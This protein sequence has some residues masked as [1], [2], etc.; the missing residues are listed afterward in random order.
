MAYSSY[1]FAVDAWK[2]NSTLARIA[3]TIAAAGPARVSAVL[4]ENNVTED[5]FKARA[6]EAAAKGIR[7]LPAYFYLGA[8][9][10]ID[11]LAKADVLVCLN[12]KECAARVEQ[13]MRLPLLRGAKLWV[14][15]DEIARDAP[16]SASMPIVGAERIL[17]FGPEVYSYV[18][19]SLDYAVDIPVYKLR[20][21]PD[22]FFDCL[23]SGER[24][25][26]RVLF[27]LL[28]SDLDESAS[29][30]YARDGRAIRG[31]A[32]AA[33]ELGHL[34]LTICGASEEALDRARS[35]I[36]ELARLDVVTV[37]PKSDEGIREQLLRCDVCLLPKRCE[38][39]GLAAVLARV[40]L[41]AARAS[42]LGSYLE[43]VGGAAAACVVDLFQVDAWA[44]RLR[45]VAAHYGE[46]LGI[47]AAAPEA[48]A[49]ADLAAQSYFSLEALAA[50][51]PRKVELPQVAPL[52]KAAA[53]TACVVCLSKP[54]IIAFVPC[55]HLCCCPACAGPLQ[56][57]VCPVCRTRVTDAVRIYKC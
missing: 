54:P 8:I 51:P 11:G 52:G 37:A 46:A 18:R 9:T 1:L 10:D 56:Q 3:A 53:D 42:D 17:A 38:R 12:R 50:L 25:D 28:F 41:I 22:P 7:L 57:R 16:G 32:A 19:T 23:V 55:G 45:H 43:D 47:A 21:L 31:A 5:Q 49:A 33:A 14:V 15:V 20:P 26:A 13:I 4:T 27:V 44:Q 39:Y 40:P 24:R 36:P 34:V 29:R 35:K 2:S 6:A 30:D 48:I